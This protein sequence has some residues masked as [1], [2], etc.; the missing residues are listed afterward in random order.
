[1]TA[2]RPP[3]S[4]GAAG[5]PLDSGAPLLAVR[6]L[7]KRFGAVLALDD[8][9]LD[10]RAGEI[11]AVLGENGA[12]KSTLMN[13][14]DGIQQADA[15]S[16]SLDGRRVRFRSARDARRAGI[17]MVHQHF[18]LVDALT[19]A[20]NLALSL[21]GQRG[22][23]FDRDAVAAEARALA[24][25]IGLQLAPPEQTVGQL[26][27]GAR[28]RLEIL[29]ALA[30]GGRVL[31]LDE[32]TAVLA[33]Q[34]VRALFDMLRGL[35]RQG[36]AIIFI[37]HKLREAREIADRITIL[38]R[39]RVVASV[40]PI[41]GSETELARLMVG[42][43]RTVASSTVAPIS[44]PPQPATGIARLTLSHLDAPA[45]DG[46]TPLR[47]VSFEVRAGEIFGIAGVDGNGQR[48]LFGVLA[49]RI[50]PARGEI[51]L[52][53]QLLR[54]LTP[55]AV[56]A[57]GIG[58]IPPDRQAD[59]L[60]LAM[61]V[62]DN[63][64]LSRVLLDRFARRGVLDIDATLAFAREQ[65]QR[66]D[67]RCS[68]IE[69]PVRSLSG[70]NQQKIIVARELAPRPRVL[71]TVNPTRGLDISGAAAVA[72][73]LRAIARGGCAVVL[74][75]TDLDE[76]LDLGARVAVLSRGRL[77]AAMTRPFDLD[78]LGL[79]MADAGT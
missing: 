38:R 3:D 37:T 74:I 66:F 34:E 20:E 2:A 41:E 13:V 77:R 31:I 47:D 44:H 56:L 22:W 60:I 51:R 43:K 69:A 70:G 73:S 33:P 11:H 32:P 15:G 21:P 67:I 27:V 52:D 6:R 40:R 61:S 7:S 42:N 59:G 65:V 29:K 54:R 57:A 1:M 50:S 16:I 25:R 48:E 30:P 79:Q 12:G 18:A 78:S 26:P 45:T 4:S 8:V 68:G 10:I 28:Q 5:G 46:G 35:R 39:G 55:A 58:H 62:A 14:L 19:V 71:V 9:S 36:R 23:R 64:L 24:A 75:S 53:G 49:G 72:D 76:I 63:F 17:G